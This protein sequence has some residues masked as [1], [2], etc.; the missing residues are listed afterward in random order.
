MSSR[1]HF[2][3]WNGDFISVSIPRALY[4]EALKLSNQLS[5]NEQVKTPQTV[6]KRKALILCIMRGLSSMRRELGINEEL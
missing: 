3:E 5:G 6:I 1:N 2:K 4:E